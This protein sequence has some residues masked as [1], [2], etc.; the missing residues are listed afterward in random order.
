VSKAGRV[1]QLRMADWQGRNCSVKDGTLAETL[2][3]QSRLSG[4]AAAISTGRSEIDRA[5]S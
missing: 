2:A 4:N 5:L 3:K 1:A